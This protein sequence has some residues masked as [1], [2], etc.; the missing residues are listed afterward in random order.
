MKTGSVLPP[1]PEHTLWCK[2]SNFEQATRVPL[3]FKTP[4]T[5][6]TT[7]KGPVEFVDVFPSLCELN[8]LPLPGH[9]QGV[10]LLPAFNNE[11]AKIKDFALS[12]FDRGPIHGYSMRNERYRLTLWMKDDFRTVFGKVDVRK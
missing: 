2:H 6:G 11:D 5:S 1:A 4:E 12:Q 9:L 7:F 3:I 10:S 8:G